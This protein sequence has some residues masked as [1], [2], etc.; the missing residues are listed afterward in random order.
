[1]EYGR[2]HD[3]MKCK[4]NEPITFYVGVIH[5]MKISHKNM[6]ENL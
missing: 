4:E 1:M 3:E 2:R 6:I 5:R